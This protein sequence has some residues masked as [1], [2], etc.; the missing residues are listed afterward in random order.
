MLLQVDLYENGTIAIVEAVSPE[1]GNRIQRVRVQV[2]LEFRSRSAHA[3][4]TPSIPHHH[5]LARGTQLLQNLDT[6]VVDVFNQVLVK[7]EAAVPPHQS[8]QA[9]VWKPSLRSALRA[10]D[11]LV[12][13]NTILQ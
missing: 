9:I 3:L 1:L 12:S 13:T 4:S 2:S 5:Q 11:M 7:L 6:L 10:L 8:V